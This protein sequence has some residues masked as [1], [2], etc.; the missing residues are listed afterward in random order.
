[1]GRVP[2][3]QIRVGSLDLIEIYQIQCGFSIY[4]D[5]F[6]TNGDVL[7]MNFNAT[8]VAKWS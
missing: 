1:M 6:N 8:E 2:G 5:F 7:Q 3:C 4:L